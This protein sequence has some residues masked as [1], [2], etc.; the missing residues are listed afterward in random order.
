MHRLERLINLVA[1]LLEAPRPLTADELRDRVPGYAAER[2]AFRRA[3]ERDKETLREMGVPVVVE[4]VDEAQ[5]GAVGYRIPKEAYYLPDPG[6]AADELA[7]LHLAA[8]AV[9]LEGADG[10]E[11]LWKLGGEVAEAGPAA[12]VA[13][14]PGQRHQAP[15]FAAISERR[16]VAFAYRGKPRTVEPHRLSFR[17]GHWYLSGT[18]LGSGDDRS[19][20]LDRIESAVEVGDQA[21]VFE[22]RAAAAPAPPWEAGTAEPV[23]AQLLVDGDQAG[24]AAGHLGA[25]AVGERRPDGSVVLRVRVTNRDAFRSFVLG[26]LDHAEVVGPP[27]LRDEMIAWL[28]ALCRA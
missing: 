4:P 2:S 12:A 6:L 20:R 18:D 25:D 27:D 13:A 23:E 10:V 11:A 7:A 16:R 8:S 26:F 19:F 28:E 14:L 15:L 1:A 3:F 5:P 24:W 9:R 17:N 21:G 22:R